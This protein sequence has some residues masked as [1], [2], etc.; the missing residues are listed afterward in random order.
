[1]QNQMNKNTQ[2]QCLIF[3]IFLM[4]NGSLAQAPIFKECENSLAPNCNQ[5]AANELVENIKDKIEEIQGYFF[6]D[7]IYLQYEIDENGSLK[8][9][10]KF[11]RHSYER[12]RLAE[13]FLMNKK[14]VFSD[15]N[16]GQSFTASLVFQIDEKKEGFLDVSA[17]QNPLPIIYCQDYNLT[18]RQGC[19]RYVASATEAYFREVGIQKTD[20]K[21][22]AYLRRGKVAGI[23]FSSTEQPNF[24]NDSIKEVV[25]YYIEFL[26]DSNKIAGSENQFIEIDLTWNRDSAAQKRYD[27]DKMDYL[28]T[29]KN[30]Q[31]YLSELLRASRALKHEERA[32]YLLNGVAEID[33]Q[34]RSNF[35]VASM[36]ISLDSLR[37][38]ANDPETYPVSESPAGADRLPVFAGCKVKFSNSK[39]RNCFQQK[40]LKYVSENFEYPDEAKY[41][42]AQGKLYINFVIEKDGRT[43]Q[44]KIVRPIHFSIDFEAIRML[45]EVP[46]MK[47]AMKGGQPVRMSFTLPINTKLE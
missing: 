13:Q 19:T 27:Q 24:L 35:R 8:I 11:N 12:G 17:T 7:S 45:S 30:K 47:P 16:R 1:M 38:F 33:Y 2:L 34:N 28:A 22:W 44:L 41:K 26:T 29:L 31:P 14:S 46:K 4:G 20:V 3:G 40:L 36:R 18:A 5:N 9:I 10:E 15:K 21:A 39:L 42:G 37:R 6:N 32:H 43:D 23:E 25:E